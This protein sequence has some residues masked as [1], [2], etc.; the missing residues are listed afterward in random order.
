MGYRLAMI[1]SGG[2]A[3]IWTDASQGGGWTWPEVYRFMAALM[4]GAAVL[5]A[6]IL[7]RRAAPRHGAHRGAATTCSAL[8]PCWP[9]WRWATC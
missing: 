7:P 6:L 2:I 9:R 1:L 8:R 5:S 4:V 3:L